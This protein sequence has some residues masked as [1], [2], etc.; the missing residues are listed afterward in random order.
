MI[1]TLIHS[2]ENNNLYIYD[3][4]FRLSIL[5]HPEFR[6]AYE[7]ST[8]VDPYYLKKYEYL[9]KYNF[10]SEAKLINFATIDESIVKNNMAQVP[11]IV[12]ET[13]D[14]CNL[15]C[16]YCSF[17]DFY[18]G[19]DARN[20]KKI[21]VDHA[22]TLLK[23]IFDLKPKSKKNQLI[24]SF[25]GGEPLFNGNF[26]KQI[27]EVTNQ[28]KLEKDI[29]IMYTMTTNATLLHKYIHFLVE[30]NFQLLIS[31][32]GD[33]INHSYRSFRENKKNSFGKVI[34][35][36]DMAQRNY[37]EYFTDCIKF[38]A[39]LH[40]RNSVKEI[41]EFIYYRYHKIPR[42]AEL[43]PNDVNLDKEDLF[44]NM[45]HD[46][47]KSEAEYVKEKSNKLPHEELLQYMEL[48]DFLKEYSINYYISNITDLLPGQKKYLPTSTC[49]PFWKKLVLTTS[50]K[51][52]LCE[53]VSYHKLT[54]GEVNETVD[55]DIQ[56]ITRQ[57]NFYYEHVKDKCQHCY[58]NKFCG[59]CLFLMKKN[60]L[61]KL[62]TE[63]FECEG[64]HDQ[65]TFNRKLHR[66]FSF[67]EKYPEDNTSIIEN[68]III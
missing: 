21:N 59:V 27:V 7:E 45:F 36:I 17:G 20:Q 13:T 3:Q 35:N 68:I 38:N 43:A 62:D 46:K 19:F 16:T 11:Q 24:I 50:S 31:L 33:E 9:K 2:S 66:V 57:Y 58:V 63:E 6:K 67:L 26:I 15:N 60:N 44:N 1:Q 64:F 8:D 39:V 65:K 18:E 12:F 49:L 22:I 52:A 51:L 55:I 42:I 53:K 54:V 23:Y 48:T 61:D 32:D 29:E 56:E 34:E 37:P 5:V 47:R 10:F 14:F 30:N 40:N 4:Q 41:Y 25:H 28:L